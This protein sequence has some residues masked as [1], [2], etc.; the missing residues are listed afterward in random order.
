M[1]EAIVE[2]AACRANFSGA[3][4]KRRRNIASALAVLSVN[5]LVMCVVFG[6]RWELRLLIAV[7]AMAAAISGLQVTRN[8]CV[9]HAA[10]GTFEHED[11]STTRVDAALAAASRKVAKTIYRD[12]LLIGLAAG[13]LAAA[14]T[15]VA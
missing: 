14:T 15:F 13:L 11:F 3:G 9:A 6:L 1:S 4:R 2:G 5:L 7:P 12:G 10:T 8:T